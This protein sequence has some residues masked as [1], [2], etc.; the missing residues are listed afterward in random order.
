[1]LRFAPS[2]S[3]GRQGQSP[4]NPAAVPVESG[5]AGRVPGPT[6]GPTRP[7][8]LLRCA[9]SPQA[10]CSLVRAC[11]P[12]PLCA[13]HGPCCAP[14]RCAGPFRRARPPPLRGPGPALC[15]RRFAPPGPPPGPG[16]PAL[17][18]GPCARLRRS[19][20][21][22]WPRFAPGSASLRCGLPNRSPLLR[23]GLPSGSTRVPRRVLPGPSAFRAPSGPGGFG[24]GWLRPG[25]LRGALPRLFWPPAP[26]PFGS[27]AVRLRPACGGGFLRRGLWL[28]CASPS[29]FSP[30]AP[31]L[32][33]RCLGSAARL[34]GAL[35]NACGG[36]LPCRPPPGR[37]RWGLPGAR[38]PLG[39]RPALGRASR[40]PVAG[41][42]RAARAARCRFS[43]PVNN[44]KI[45]NRGLTPA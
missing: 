39:L 41:P 7:A 25:G 34:P 38:G 26:G 1:M 18:L 16:P 13:L 40:D 31:T 2:F 8:R 30:A 23:F 44:P 32:G 10:V 29:A 6:R 12:G 3:P 36:L 17:A 14:F 28:G 11:G 19:V 27:R 35:H 15:A 4:S 5:P 20:G 24:G 22:R 37:P 9:T 42:R 21:A 43:G 33:P 45:V